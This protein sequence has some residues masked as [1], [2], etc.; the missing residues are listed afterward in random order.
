[1]ATHSSAIVSGETVNLGPL[2]F[3]LL[4]GAVRRVT[5]H[6]REV[7]RGVSFAVR[8]TS[9]GTP[10]PEDSSER[11][12]ATEEEIRVRRR[13]VYTEGL[14]YTLMFRARRTGHLTF[15]ARLT[16]KRRTAINRAGFI[17]L[18]PLE[19]VAGC[20]VEIRHI[21]GTLE[22][23]A[24]PEHICSEQPYFNIAGISHVV[25][26][27]RIAIE[28]EGETFE[29]EDQRNWSDASFKTYC[30]P[31][32]SPR[33]RYLVPGE[34]LNQ[35]ISVEL[36]GE[37]RGP[38][39]AVTRKQIETTAPEI[40]LAAEPGWL[41]G[42][43]PPGVRLLARFAEATK[44]SDRDFAALAAKG[45]VDAEIVL[46]QEPVVAEGALARLS[47]RLADAGVA[48]ER[49]VGLP[50]AYLKR[51]FPD[52]PMP[53]GL[54]L[55]AA[56]KLSARAF[57]FA[58]A[59]AGVLTHFTELNR[60]QPPT[61]IGEYITHGN[62]A[63]LHAADDLS[64][65]ETLEGLL[66][67]MS[68]ART[69]AGKR[70]YR[71]GLVAIGMRSNPHGAGLTPN[72]DGDKI[73]MTR[74][75]PRQPTSFAAAYAVAAATLAA[76]SGA[77]AICLGAPSG[78]FGIA[79]DNG[80]LF[81]IGHAA[82]ALA[83]LSGPG[84]SASSFDGVFRL[85]RDDV[86]VTANCSFDSRAMPEGAPSDGL[87]LEGSSAFTGRHRFLPPMS[88]HITAGASSV[89]ATRRQESTA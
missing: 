79:D 72:P 86:T 19:G 82:S 52:A 48:V 14:E 28:M 5:W 29:M 54:D 55:A 34:V 15:D 63:I 76:Q 78:P 23:G 66:H 84:V 81:P 44:W 50:E 22:R 20:P 75:D 71:L 42:A 21:D 61:G 4:D 87:L 51:L 56:S 37:P 13:S 41:E 46:P 32:A 24:W 65:V 27:A 73:P 57:P 64:V 25:Y 18:H 30:P 69:I 10:V 16:A 3:L 67:V 39:K 8:D 45:P 26:G 77:Q 88:C 47:A 60:C 33:P 40:L 9:W 11:F 38:A 1:M 68:A 58:R 36:S 53:D 80:V 31:L 17:L 12:E 74:N 83:A 49:I 59:G 6:E 2:S 43:C 62:T 7:L 85:S 70:E 35:Q 89:A